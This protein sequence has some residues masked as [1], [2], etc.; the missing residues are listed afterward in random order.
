MPSFGSHFHALIILSSSSILYPIL[1]TPSSLLPVLSKLTILA[2]SFEDLTDNSNVWKKFQPIRPCRSRAEIFIL[3][4][5]S[6]MATRKIKCLPKWEKMAV[7][8][9]QNWLR[10]GIEGPSLLGPGC[11]R[12]LCQVTSCSDSQDGRSQRTQSEPLGDFPAACT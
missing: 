5:C 4:T 6:H 8:G 1:S 12:G 10:E 7:T 2:V 3:A 11:H 9:A